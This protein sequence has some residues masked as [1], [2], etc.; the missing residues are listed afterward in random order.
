MRLKT[1]FLGPQNDD[2]FIDFRSQKFPLHTLQEGLPVEQNQG[3]W[4]TKPRTFAGR[5]DNTGNHG[6]H[7]IPRYPELKIII[8]RCSVQTSIQFINRNVLENSDSSLPP[9]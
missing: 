1:R 5:Q 8:I 3:F 9:A 2:D 4:G 7:Y 6:L